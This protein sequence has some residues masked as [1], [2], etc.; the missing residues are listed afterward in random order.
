MPT[1]LQFLMPTKQYFFVRYF[2][3]LLCPILLSD[4]LSN[5]LSDFFVRFFIRFSLSDL[6]ICPIFLFRFS[7]GFIC[8]I[9]SLEHE[10]AISCSIFLSDLFGSIY[11]SDFCPI[12]CRNFIRFSM[13]DFFVR[14]LLSYFLSDLFCPTCSCPIFCL[15]FLSDL[16]LSDFF[17]I[18][19]SDFMSD[20]CPIFVRFSMSD[21]L[22]PIFLVRIFGPTCSCPIFFVRFFCPILSDLFY[23]TCFF[24]PNFCPLFLA[25]LLSHFCVIS[26]QKRWNMSRHVL[27]PLSC[28]INVLVFLLL[29]Q[30]RTVLTSGGVI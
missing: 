5:F 27:P 18:F 28:T 6:I 3:P 2:V 19:W 15:I 22:C 17:P 9:F 12:S 26:R 7:V 24:C 4:F 20:F 29:W 10:I 30:Y 11:M 21:F 1:P 14:I 16:F 25:D 8:L 13:S 23:P